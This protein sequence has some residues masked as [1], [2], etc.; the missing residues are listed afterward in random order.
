[1]KWKIR[2]L[3]KDESIETQEAFFNR[4]YQISQKS[5]YNYIRLIKSVPLIFN[6]V[7]A[8]ESLEIANE[9]LKENNL[10]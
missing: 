4:F 8:N 2:R 7:I 9:L 3:L 5:A 1:M 10:L 6:L